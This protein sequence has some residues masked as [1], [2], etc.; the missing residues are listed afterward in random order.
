MSELSSFLFVHYSTSG[1]LVLATTLSVTAALIYTMFGMNNRTAIR[2]T[3]EAVTSPE[4]AVE[5]ALKPVGEILNFR[6]GQC[7]FIENPGDGGK[8]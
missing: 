5:V 6:P 8:R 4:R 7:S 3:N 2:I 1:L